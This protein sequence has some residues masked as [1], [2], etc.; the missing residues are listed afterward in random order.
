MPVPRQARERLRWAQD[1]AIATCGRIAQFWGFTRS[2]GRAFGLLYV[3]PEPLTQAE[4]QRRLRIS[5]GNASMTLAA[6]VRWGVVFKVAVRGDR[7]EHYRSETDFWKMISRVLNERERQEIRA[8]TEVVTRAET[9]AREARRSFRGQERTQADHVARRLAGLREI[10]AIGETML[11]ML[12][13]QLNLDV[14]RFR[15]VFRREDRPT[16]PNGG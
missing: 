5:A 7:R 11:D 2:M 12:L 3:S 6:L 14:A 1:Q 9:A 13:G 16:P 15:D 4:V 10:C 8:A